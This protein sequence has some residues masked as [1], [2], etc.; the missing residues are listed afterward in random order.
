MLG[1]VSSVTRFRVSEYL[2]QSMSNGSIKLNARVGYSRLAECGEVVAVKLSRLDRSRQSAHRSKNLE[3]QRPAWQCRR[4]EV[5]RFRWWK[6]ALCHKNSGL[7]RG[8]RVQAGPRTQCQYV[9][10]RSIQDRHSEGGTMNRRRAIEV[11]ASKRRLRSIRPTWSQKIRE[12]LSCDMRRKL[13]I[14]ACHIAINKEVQ[15]RM[16]RYTR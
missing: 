14:F 10:D 9:R 7:L 4:A 5:R 15:F 8:R 2:C 1:F 3:A 11:E 16:R 6:H 12:R 13:C